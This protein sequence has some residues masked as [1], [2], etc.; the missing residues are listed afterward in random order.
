LVNDK[1]TFFRLPAKDYAERPH[2]LGPEDKKRL[3]EEKE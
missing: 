3:D 2:E 1:K